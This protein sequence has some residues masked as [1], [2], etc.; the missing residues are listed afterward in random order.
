[1]MKNE[2]MYQ[3]IRQKKRNE[4]DLPATLEVPLEEFE[5]RTR[6]R[7]IYDVADFCKGQAFGDAGYS[8][9]MRRPVI[10]RNF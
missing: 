7:K 3:T 10:M 5:S 9:D 6:D 1:M 2:A 4:E 8:L